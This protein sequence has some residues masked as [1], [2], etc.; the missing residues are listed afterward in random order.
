MNKIVVLKHNWSAFRGR[1]NYFYIWYCPCRITGLITSRNVTD[2]FCSLRQ[3]KKKKSICSR[4]FHL[5]S[6]QLVQALGYSDAHIH[7]HS[8]FQ[9]RWD[10]AHAG[11]KKHT[12]AYLKPFLQLTLYGSYCVLTQ[13]L[14]WSYRAWLSHELGQHCVQYDKGIRTCVGQYI[15]MVEIAMTL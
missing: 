11:V 8:H 5:S 9:Q 15:N 6:L 3:K 12:R 14:Q 7:T 10:S 2:A 1:Q 13:T 4:S